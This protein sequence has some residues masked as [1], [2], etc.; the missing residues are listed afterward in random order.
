MRLSICIPVFNNYNLTRDCLRDLSFLPDDH[1]VIVWDNA[2]TDETINLLNLPKNELP[3]NFKYRRSD[4]NLGFAGGSNSAYKES[5]GEFILFLNNDIRVEKNHENWTNFL[6]NTADKKNGIV[7][8]TVGSLHINTC[9]FSGEVTASE[10]N[11]VLDVEKSNH[12]KDKFF[13]YISGWCMC[14]K[15]E[16]FDKLIESST[17]HPFSEE[18]G[19]AFHEDP[20]ICKRAIML[21]IKMYQ[22]YVP[23]NHLKHM[24][25]KK[26][27][28]SKLYIESREIFE[29]KWKNKLP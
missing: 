29:A 5:E 27:N 10:N 12:N 16:I 9:I 4:S 24:T 11:F 20:D 21:G 15:K 1:E 7:G 18:F 25:A 17:V 6:T 13:E 19:L 22:Q 28:M 3:K 26:L 23:V 8:P 14:A 2:S